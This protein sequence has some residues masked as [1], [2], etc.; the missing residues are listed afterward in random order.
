MHLSP[1]RIC[2]CICVCVAAAFAGACADRN[3]PAEPDAAAQLTLSSEPLEA[4]GED[5][6]FVEIAREVASFGGSGSVIRTRLS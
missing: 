6:P 2:S 5:P 3:T 1:R 4:L